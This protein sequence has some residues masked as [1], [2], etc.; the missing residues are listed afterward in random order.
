V[1]LYRQIDSFALFMM[2]ICCFLFTLIVCFWVFLVQSFV[3]AVVQILA[4]RPRSRILLFLEYRSNKQKNKKFCDTFVSFSV[5]VT[6]LLLETATGNQSS[7][8]RE[9]HGKVVNDQEEENQCPRKCPEC[10][11]QV[12]PQKKEEQIEEMKINQENQIKRYQ[13][14]RNDLKASDR[15]S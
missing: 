6:C 10:K 5:D 4:F 9:Q 15:L 12:L 13:N 2:P 1:E 11:L 3:L 14:S 8:S 7:C